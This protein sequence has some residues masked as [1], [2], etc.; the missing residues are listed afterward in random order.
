M[1]A[2]RACDGP[3]AM[4]CSHMQMDA[5]DRGSLCDALD[6]SDPSSI[7]VALECYRKRRELVKI[8]ASQSC[9]DNEPS[10][11]CTT[12]SVLCGAAKGGNPELPTVTLAD[13]AMTA[14]RAA[15][16]GQQ[17]QEYFVYRACSDYEWANEGFC[18]FAA[19]ISDNLNGRSLAADAASVRDQE[20]TE[21]GSAAMMA[22]SET[23]MEDIKN[24]AAAFGEYA[25][26]EDVIVAVTFLRVVYV[27]Q[28][29]ASAYGIGTGTYATLEGDDGSTGVDVLVGGD[30][31]KYYS[32][33]LA[34]WVLSQV[35][36]MG[37]EEVEAHALPQEYG[38]E[39]AEADPVYA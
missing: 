36:N 1:E 30:S 28:L 6:I 32:G 34:K 24:S 11:E 26:D 8:G 19:A 14:I 39:Q 16:D 21:Y 2:V 7:N 17:P 33:A 38:A 29:V 3:L 20:E 13:T 18:D 22:V 23:E 4:C 35:K 25:T 5:F 31:P 27:N 9:P 10:A 37:M 15:L 12:L